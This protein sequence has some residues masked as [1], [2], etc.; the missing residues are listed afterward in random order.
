MSSNVEDFLHQIQ[1]VFHQIKPKNNVE[2]EDQTKN[3]TMLHSGTLRVPMSDVIHR[4]KV[5]DSMEVLSF[6]IILHFY[7]GFYLFLMNQPF[8][9]MMVYQAFIC[10]IS[11]SLFEY[12]FFYFVFHPFFK[13]H[14]KSIVLPQILYTLF[15]Y[16]ILLH[17]YPFY[18]TIFI[19]IVMYHLSN[20][21]FH[22]I[23]HIESKKIRTFMNIFIYF[24]KFFYIKMIHY[25][26]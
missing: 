22:N 24:L 7:M 5:I 14:N 10:G 11:Y 15:H 19:N 13:N 9:A 21:Y 26:F 17:S 8:V 12:N 2:K 20:S 23:E 6:S 3:D 1:N 25:F 16:Y 4:S 18:I